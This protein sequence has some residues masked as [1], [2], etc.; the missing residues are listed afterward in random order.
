MLNRTAGVTFAYLLTLGAASGAMAEQTKTPS[1]AAHPAAAHP[2]V[3]EVAH[4]VAN[5]EHRT[6]EGVDHGRMDRWQAER[7]RR[8]EE[9]VE[10]QLR[11]DEMMHDG[12]ITMGE[13]HRLNHEL[14]RDAAMQA[15]QERWAEQHGMNPIPD[16]HQVMSNG[17]IALTAQPAVTPPS[18]PN[19]IKI[20]TPGQ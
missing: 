10:R 9:W 18:D 5:Q 3:S 11:H 16:Q 4:R 12:H 19:T 15:R 20:N 1:A 17:R 14:D 6:A 13:E 8:R 7:D 2:R